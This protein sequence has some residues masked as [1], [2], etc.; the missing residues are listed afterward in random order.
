M[1]VPF[2]REEIGTHSNSR[3]AGTRRMPSREISQPPQSPGRADSASRT[4]CRGALPVAALLCEAARPSACAMSAAK[5][6][7]PLDGVSMRHMNRTPS[8]RRNCRSAIRWLAPPRY[9][10]PASRRRRLFSS[11]DYAVCTREGFHPSAAGGPARSQCAALRGQNLPAIIDPDQGACEK[12]HLRLRAARL[13]STRKIR[14]RSAP[15]KY[16][17]LVHRTSQ[18]VLRPPEQRTSTAGTP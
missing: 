10:R 11:T 12:T 9:T 7:R 4:L 5:A 16:A 15:S 6:V 18:A 14:R 2:G 13:L 8:R 1:Q 3:R 17:R